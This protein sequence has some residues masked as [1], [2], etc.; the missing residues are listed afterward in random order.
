M[1]L[2]ASRM[3]C[4]GFA[5]AGLLLF[6]SC[7]SKKLSLSG[8]AHVIAGMKLLPFPVISKMEARVHAGVS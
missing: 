1:A 8:I 3:I 5:L 4:A 7:D 2:Q 6:G